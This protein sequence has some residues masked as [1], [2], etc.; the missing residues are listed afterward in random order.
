LIVYVVSGM[1]P[2]A[3]SGAVFKAAA[4]FILPVLLCAGLVV[5]FP[6]IATFLPNLIG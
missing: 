2:E 5:A 4:W 1:V 6:Q 3:S